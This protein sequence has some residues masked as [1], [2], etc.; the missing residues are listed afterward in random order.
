MSAQHVVTPVP[1]V[2]RRVTNRLAI[3]GSGLLLAA[4]TLLA[5]LPVA[6]AG[7]PRISDA[8]DTDQIIVAWSD[9]AGNVRAAEVT[10]RTGHSATW[11]RRAGA[12]DVYRL[13]GSVTPNAV[14]NA[15]AAM[16]ATPGVAYAEP[17]TKLYA[18]AAAPDDT[19]F[20]N[21]QW[22][23]F[24]GNTA[25]TY[26]I[27]ALT[28][29][30]YSR[31]AG[32]NVA[33]IDT[34]IT[35]HPD[36]AGQTVAGYDFISTA[37]VANDGGGRDADP[38]DPG[39]WYG[40]SSSSW[41]GTHVTGTIVALTNNT[42]GIAG[43]APEAKVQP[44][45]V[46]GTGGGYTSDIAD[47]VIWASGGTVS[48][49]PANPTP[50]R[51]LSLSLGG[52]GTCGATM[53]NAING[54]VG[55]GSVVVVAAGNSNANASGFSPANCANII[56]VAATDRTGARASFSN[57]GTMVEIA[58]PGVSMIS[59]LNTGTTVPAQPTYAQYSGTSMATPHVS[60]IVAL[61]LAANPSL[62]PAQVLLALQQTAHGFGGAGCS[63]G[64]GA[65]IAN[66]GAAVALA[67]TGVIPT[68]TPAPTASPTPTPKPTPVPTPTPVTCT[69]GTPTV[70][71]TPTAASVTRGTS[72]TVTIVVANKDSAAC[73][74]SKFT[75][76]RSLS[77]STS[78]VSSTLAVSSLT[79]AAGA[80]ASTTA[81]IAVTTRASANRTATVTYTATRSTS[82]R[83]ASAKVTVTI[84]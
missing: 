46:L 18:I 75:M 55:R 43:I 53:Q 21:Y 66:A 54:A 56:T 67:A 3:I 77:G 1:P 51:V 11:V 26:G 17:D 82:P 6:A 9:T 28:A 50:S 81:T 47:A 40:T 68:P 35:V 39:D 32:V 63:A 69:R 2:R 16:R 72:A 71:V 42:T 73:A 44:V 84:K 62:T 10:S 83:T 45:R 19:Y 24:E 23:L 5:A 64:C 29:W 49:V 4:A 12:V 30:D 59:T 31:G 38:S 61:M 74:S 60:G 70:T 58:A 36:L 33:V 7:A 41:H 13:G 8:V 48:G 34:G 20:A 25:S 79:I 14:A 76:S 78:G 15:V 37:S 52:T 27:D 22:D 57:Y 65:G 80:S